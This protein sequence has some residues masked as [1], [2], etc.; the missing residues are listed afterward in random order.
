[1]SAGNTPEARARHAAGS[2]RGRE[3]AHRRV[4]TVGNTSAKGR[5]GRARSPWDAGPMCDT[6]NA[7][8]TFKRNR[9]EQS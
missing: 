3:A 9:P 4:N 8:R 2:A 7:V 5:L 1:M 6:P